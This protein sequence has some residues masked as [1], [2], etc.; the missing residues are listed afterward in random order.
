MCALRQGRGTAY[1][2]NVYRPYIFDGAVCGPTPQG[3]LSWP[4]GPIHLLWASPPTEHLRIT[5]QSIAQTLGGAEGP[6]ALSPQQCE[7]WIENLTA[8]I[9]RYRTKSLKNPNFK[10]FTR[11]FSKNRRGPGG[12]APG[13]PSQRAKCPL[14]AASETPARRSGR[15]S[16]T[17]L[18]TDAP[19]RE[20]PA[21]LR[22]ACRRL[23]GA[24]IGDRRRGH[25]PGRCGPQ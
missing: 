3:G 14:A 16:L 7:A 12:S 4:A 9:R 24:G 15:N 19:A 17:A 11:F 21:G 20:W 13:R 18:L 5:N 23:R 22:P 25:A 6:L 1:R 2:A 10:S 8:Q